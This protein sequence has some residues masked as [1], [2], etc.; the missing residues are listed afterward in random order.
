MASPRNVVMSCQLDN[1]LPASVPSRA[2][3]CFEIR[4]T[5][6]RC[7]TSVR[8]AVIPYS[9]PIPDARTSFP[10]V[11]LDMR[12]PA[13]LMARFHFID[14]ITLIPAITWYPQIRV[15]RATIK[16]ICSGSPCSDVKES[17]VSQRR[18]RNS[19]F[20]NGSLLPRLQPSQQ[21][22]HRLFSHASPPALSLHLP[23]L[24]TFH[25]SSASASQSPAS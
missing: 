8:W 2:G 3:V 10:W 18:S 4:P 19:S 16:I 12:I 5:V 7:S 23:A 24:H 25:K 9:P 15:V 6:H 1:F 13:R 17:I 20:T 11:L 14:A 21:S 22:S